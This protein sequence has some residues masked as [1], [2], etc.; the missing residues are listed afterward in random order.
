MALEGATLQRVGTAFGVP[1][2]GFVSRDDAV[3]ELLGAVI[4]DGRRGASTFFDSI[5]APELRRHVLSL[6]LPAR[7]NRKAAFVTTLIHDYLLT[8]PLPPI[9]ALLAVDGGAQGSYP[10]GSVYRHLDRRYDKRGLQKLLDRIEQPRSA[11]NKRVL[12]RRIFETFLWRE[13]IP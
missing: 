1:F 2:A 10:P 11:K 9:R 12:I 3:D 4:A 13:L 6:A 7:T 5:P 8:D